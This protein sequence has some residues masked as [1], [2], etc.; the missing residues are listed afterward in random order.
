MPKAYVR[1][2]IIPNDYK[3]VYNLFGMDSTCPNDIQKAIDQ[4]A[5]QMLDVDI[6]SPGGVISAGSEI[7][8]M[9]RSYGNVRNHIVGQ[10]CSAA[11]IISMSA[12]CDMA[13]TAL[14][15]VHCVSTS[16]GNGNHT[17]FEHTAEMLRTADAALCTAYTEKSGMSQ[18]EALTMME[19]ETWL[20]AEMALERHLIDQIMYQEDVRN[21]PQV[22]TAGQIYLPDTE[23]MNLIRNFLQFMSTPD[24]PNSAPG[25][26]RME[27]M[28]AKLKLLHL[29]GELR[30][31]L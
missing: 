11:S 3:W 8:T 7:Y 23:Q 26:I 22:M 16:G 12:W 4:A 20:T 5:G 17:Q 15:M 13:P 25:D 24:S 6:N 14:M 29:K 30:N 19:H 28:K 1:G 27:T 10:A 21:E 2:S 9:L 31:D 18:E